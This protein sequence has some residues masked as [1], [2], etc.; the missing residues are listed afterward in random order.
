MK[1]KINDWIV[2]N[3]KEWSNHWKEIYGISLYGKIGKII[4][5]DIDKNANRDP[6]LIE[7]K[8]FIDS[9]D[10]YYG[11]GKYGHCY[12]G[13]EEEF[14]LYKDYFKLKKFIEG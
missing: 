6:Y 11:I 8:D 2:Y 12:W 7:F 14:T 13:H 4:Y 3:N 1:Y 9:H 5:I 10:R